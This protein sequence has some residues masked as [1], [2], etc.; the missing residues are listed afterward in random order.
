MFLMKL[1]HLRLLAAGLIAAGL[2]TVTLGLNAQTAVAQSP[3]HPTFPLLDADGE[4]VLET[5]N[6][7]STITTC[8]QCHDTAF[9]AAHNYHNDVG[10]SF[11]TEAGETGSGRAWDT[12]S[13][14]FGKW[15]PITYRYLSPAGDPNV[16]LD[17]EAWIQTYG[18]RHAGGG[19][20]AEAGVEINCF[21]CHL[22]NPD[23]ESRIEAL[24]ASD[25]E[26]AS[27]ATLLNTEVVSLSEGEYLWNETAFDPQ[28]EILPAVV[29][30]HDPTDD[31]CGLCHGTVHTETEEALTITGC[32]DNGYST[33]TTGQV[34]TAQ[35]LDDTGMNIKDKDQLGYSWDVHIE[36][37]VE[38]VDCHYSLNNPVYTSGSGSFSLEH[39]DYDPRRVE[40]GE[41][42]VQPMHDFARGESAQ[43]T[44]SPDTKGTIRRCEGCHNVENS[45]DWLPYIE[46]HMD[47]M[48]CE[49][50][51][52]PQIHNAATQ[53]VD[54]TVVEL[55]GSSQTACRGVDGDSGTINDLVTGYAPVLIQR[56]NLDGTTKLAP[57]NLISSWFWVYGDPQRPVRQ[58]DL[59]TVFL[60]GEGYTSDVVAFFDADNSGNI[61]AGELQLNTEEK[62]SFIAAKLEELGLNNPR[63]SAEVQP[64]SI[65]HD[66]IEGQLATSEC[67]ACHSDESRVTQPIQLASYIPGDVLPKFVQDS[68]TL[69]N[70][71]IYQ[72]EDGA[73]YYQPSP[74]EEG[75]YLFGHDNVAWVDWFG[76]IM[77][78]GVLGGIT[79]HAGL[80]VWYSIKHPQP[81]HKTKKI[82]MY[83]MY[84]RIWH[85]LQ[86]L[87]ITILAFTG[88]IIHKPEMFG[89]F[90]FN[91]VVLVHNIVAATLAINAVLALF[92]NLVSGDIQRFLPEPQ[93]FFNQMVLQGKF[94][95]NGIFKGEEHPFEKTRVK[96][97]NVLQKITYLG[98]LNVLLPLQGLTGILMWGVSRWPEYAA[99]LGGLPFLAP[100]HTLVAWSF[101]SFIVAHVYLT[102]TGHTPL[103]GIKSMFVGWDEV[104]VHSDSHAEE[105]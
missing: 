5:G 29:E 68:N 96:R 32:E 49:S 16:D 2:L 11:Q 89:I 35:R 7:V 101:V 69:N 8:G 53:Q 63:I 47:A 27:T 83:T 20:A 39:L 21:L 4:H 105:E 19:P 98:I 70:G 80:R 59:E 33:T 18:L 95:L 72:D 100:F 46:T 79:G 25:F 61:E 87:S 66:V 13:G 73:L 64:Y 62:V 77:F 26:W 74:Q 81:K 67:T 3:L 99:K 38:C 75:M 91:G 56:L 15:D 88:L 36:R 97:L 31:N 54:W 48:L 90:S 45:H 57:Y 10:F 12:S 28:G 52:I 58:Q 86:T 51:H 43:S 9:I 93:G 76:V 17:T 103:A 102:T 60:D 44:V 84:E 41:Y 22:V 42:I 55:D 40:L 23:N 104:E 65:S 94:Y 37:Q 85:W 34:I 82:E 71:E 6:P 30:V 92:Y 1:K 14:L 78:L 50:C 24:E